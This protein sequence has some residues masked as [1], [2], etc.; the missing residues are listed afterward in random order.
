MSNELFTFLFGFFCHNG[1]CFILYRFTS[2]FDI[3]YFPIFSIAISLALV[4]WHS[5][6]ENMILK[7][8]VTN[9]IISWIQWVY[10]VAFQNGVNGTILC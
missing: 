4:Q 8:S 2:H 9:S 10:R 7:R 5:C 3:T 1:V 6:F